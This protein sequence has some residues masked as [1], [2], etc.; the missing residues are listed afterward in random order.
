MATDTHRVSLQYRNAQIALLCAFA[1]LFVLDHSVP[2][3]AIH[4]KVGGATLVA[5]GLLLMLA[6]FV[7][8]RAVIQVAP[9][10]KAGGHLITSGPYRWLRHP[11][12]TGMLLLF[13]GLFLRKPTAAVGIASA[14]MVAFLMVK[15]AFE[16]ELL[17]ARYPEYTAYRTRTW[18]VLPGIR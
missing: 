6:A 12:Y 18:G 3:E 4:F 13:I 9:E 7:S 17:Q 8:L 10:P 16:E 1:L 11:I 2:L 14:V 15:A 5:L